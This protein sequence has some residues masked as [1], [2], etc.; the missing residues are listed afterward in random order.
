[1]L[2]KLPGKSM[3]IVSVLILLALT[4]TAQTIPAGTPITVRIGSEIS[5]GTAKAGDRF[6]ATLAHSLVVNGKT[7]ARTGAP[8]RGKVT[9]AKS[10]GRL[11]APGELGLRLTSV[12]VNG[13]MVPVSTRSIL[14]RARAIPKAMRPKLVAARQ[15]AR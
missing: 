12:Q 2:G 1:M 11:H 5:S 14:P 8:A 15:P 4:A 10:S 7:L 13:R 9:S 3:K 6:D